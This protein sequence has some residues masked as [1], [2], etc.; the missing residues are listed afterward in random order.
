MPPIKLPRIVVGGFQILRSGHL[1]TCFPNI[2]QITA[3][4]EDDPK[5]KKRRLYIA[6][7]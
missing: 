4:S 6:S 1:A 3:A 2:R 7:R 5:Q